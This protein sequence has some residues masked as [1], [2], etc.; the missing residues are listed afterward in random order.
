M[1]VEGIGERGRGGEEFGGNG[2]GARLPGGD[3][4]CV[5]SVEVWD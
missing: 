5:D 3:E 1:G 4:Q 2:E